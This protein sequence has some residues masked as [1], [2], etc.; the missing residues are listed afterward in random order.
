MNATGRQGRGANEQEATCGM[1]SRKEQGSC[2]M[3]KI[4][5]AA[6][7]RKVDVSRGSG[8]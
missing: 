5:M 1:W 2:S 7:E 8:R 4:R 3:T 6:C